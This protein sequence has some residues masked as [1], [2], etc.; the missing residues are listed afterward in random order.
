MKEMKK[1]I[2]QNVHKFILTID[3][4]L[5]RYKWVNMAVKATNLMLPSFLHVKAKL[6]KERF[7]VDFEL[8]CLNAA[9]IGF[10]FKE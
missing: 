1:G 8:C 2:D 6:F 7:S 5:L 3:L 10:F 4:I 9:T